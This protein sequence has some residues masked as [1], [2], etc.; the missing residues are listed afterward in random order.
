MPETIDKPKALS[1]VLHTADI[2][3]PAKPW[4]LHYKW[5]M[6]LLEEFFRQGDREK[7]LGK[8]DRN[9]ARDRDL[10]RNRDLARDRHLA[11]DRQL[12]RGKHVSRAKL[13]L[14]SFRSFAC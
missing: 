7:E 9:L 10:A 4:E 1:L 2:S 13:I 11:R 5:T 8:R 14:Y 12:A 6:N 3:H